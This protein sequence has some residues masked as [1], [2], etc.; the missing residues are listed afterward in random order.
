MRI[1]ED[2]HFSFINN[3]RAG[4][5][6]SGVLLLLSVISF[7][8]R[9]LELGID[10]RG[11]MSFVVENTEGMRPVD[12]RGALTDA[13]G[14]EPEVK[15]FGET[16][17]LI[18]TAA[19]GDPNEV[20]GRMMSSLQEAYPQNDLEIAK[21]DIVGPRFA[22]D[23]AEGALWAIVG[24]LFIIFVY[25]L[26]RFEWRFGVGA[27]A[28]LFHDVTITL[29][30]FSLLAGIAPFSLQI[31]QAIIAAFLTIVGYSL[32]D[33]VVV[34]D[35]IREYTNLF[36]TEAYDDIVNRSINNTLSRTLVTSGT[37]L[38]VVATLFIFGGEVLKGFAFALIIGI[39]IGT[40]SSIFVASPVVVELKH[41]ADEKREAALSG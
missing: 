17:L 28:A 6:F 27:V 11:G 8:T 13:F 38:L 32:N 33:T 10:F 14:A 7:A 22:A 23:L 4:Y 21:T 9:G 19:E 26:I 40:Y 35:R 36:K 12:V 18:R 24:S 41:Y 37:T 30:V 1:F 5:I 39:M 15:T 31:D 34:F 29:G 25:I 16:G 2:T 3:R 20:Q